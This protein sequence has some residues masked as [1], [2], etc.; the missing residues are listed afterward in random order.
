MVR[1]QKPSQNQERNHSG[2]DRDKDEYI[3][4]I[5]THQDDLQDAFAH[6]DSSDVDSVLSVDSGEAIDEFYTTIDHDERGDGSTDDNP[7]PDNP[8]Y[9]D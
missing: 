1:E 3:Q 4:H 7:D 5:E 2:Y 6:G 9:L 8:E